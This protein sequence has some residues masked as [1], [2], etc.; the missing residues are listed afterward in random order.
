MYPKFQRNKLL[1]CICLVLGT[2]TVP[3]ALAQQAPQQEAEE[4][5]MEVIEVSG[6][7]GSLSKALMTKRSSVNARESIAAE[8]IGKFP[9]LNIAE[10]LQRVPGVAISREGGE[11]RQIT[12]RGLGPSFTR[13]TLNGM[14]VPA[15][16]DGTDSGGGVNN[17]R[18]FDYNVFASELFNRVDIQKSPTAS[19]EEGGIAGTVDLYTAKPLDDTGFHVA[20][21]AQ[22]GYNDVTE[23]TDPRLALMVSNTFADDTFGALFSVAMSERTVRQ[24]GFGTVRWTTPVRDGGGVFADTSNTNVSGTANVGD[25]QND[26][27]AVDPINCLWTPR[28]PRPDFFG[29]EQERLGMTASFQ[30]APSD[31]VL[32]TFD[33]LQSTLD[34]ERTMYNFFEMFRSTF[35][36]ITPLDITIHPNGKQ[37]LAGRYDGI[38]SRIESRQQIS[39]TDFSQYVLSGDFFVSDNLTLKALLGTAESDARSEQY[40][41]NMTN[42]T[43][44]VYGF[45]FSNNANVPTLEYGYDTN[46]ESLYDLSDGR[47]RATDVVR[48]N[49]TA[50]LDLTYYSDDVVIKTGLA[51]NN[52]VVSYSEEQINGF[53][54]QASAVGF[55]Q[56]LPYSD[57]GNGFDGPLDRFIVADFGQI[58]SQLLD[59]TWSPRS[60]QSWEVEEETLAGYLEFNSEYDIADMILRANFGIR[61]VKTDTTSSG[62]IQQDK[63]SITNGYSNFLPAMNLALDATDEMVV[64]LG[65]S[66]SMTRPSLS[67]L[68]PGNPSFSY[69]NGT[70]S[71]G[72]PFLD[73]FVSN[74]VDVSFEWYFDDEAL[75]A[76]TVFYKDIETFITSSTEERLVDPAYLPFIDND[77]Q[78]DPQ[79]ALDPRVVPYTH[80]VPVNGEG[81][82]LRGYEL[83]YQQPFTFLP[84]GLDGFGVVANYTQVSSGEITGLSENSYNFT[85]YYEQDQYGARISANTRDDYIT[86]YSGSN[87]NAEHGTT[88][89]TH[90]DFTAFYNLNE[91]LTLTLEVIN[92]TDEYERLFTTG[93]GSLDLMR[94]YNH[95]GRQFFFGARYTM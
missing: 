21:S 75:F 80:N 9:D 36:E 84:E 78:Y 58:E 40:R 30:Y 66:R 28:L 8:D 60:A 69:I 33:A 3:F 41:Y 86:D 63:V 29:N 49:D 27:V 25:C 65:V 19:M 38:K 79:I 68:N 67:S 43:P 13:S 22:G 2:H 17:G 46:D 44:H 20:A 18:A 4:E 71:A 34:N 95:T 23:K 59:K 81:T 88:G 62:F 55:T 48:D 73:P 24:E 15:S 6:F 83:I 91:Q 52:R 57:F 10:S 87:G 12:L 16:T 92:L 56:P 94:E 26:G 54:D 70:V 45:D 42:N 39:S 64:R 14:E 89:P 31:A 32:I 82:D 7:R 74:N 35:S 1:S 77:P 37:V 53:P 61:Y 72:N 51:F 47:L 5:A 90:V 11:G 76:A 93:D 50:K 85:L